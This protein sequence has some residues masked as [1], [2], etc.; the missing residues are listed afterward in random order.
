MLQIVVVGRFF[1]VAYCRSSTQCNTLM[2]VT[3]PR[4]I[5]LAEC[6][7]RKLCVTYETRE[8]FARDNE[9]LRVD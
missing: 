7:T 6:E 4:I 5:R 1:V 3:M 8:V 2:Q 9:G